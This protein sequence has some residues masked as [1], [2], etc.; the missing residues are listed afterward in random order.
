MRED[1]T[2]A[3]TIPCEAR[4]KAHPLAAQCQVSDP[5]QADPF[6]PGLAAAISLALHQ[7]ARAENANWLNMLWPALDG[8]GYC[9]G[10][11]H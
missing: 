9:Y 5:G 3:F 6:A 10:S 7:L 2:R 1:E 11:G 4:S 8:L